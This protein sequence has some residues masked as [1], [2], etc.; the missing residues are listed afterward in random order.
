MPQEL[1]NLSAPLSLFIEPTNFCNFKCQVCPESLVD[2]EEQA[3]Y[4]QKMSQQTWDLLCGQLQSWGVQFPVIR[5]YGMGEPTLNPLLPQM[6]RDVRSFGS[7]TELTTNGSRLAWQAQTLIYSGLSYVRVSIYGTDD[8]EYQTAT[9]SRTGAS[10]ILE[11]VKAFW[12]T[13]NFYYDRGELEKKPWLSVSLVSAN[14]DE[15][16]FRKQYEGVADDLQVERLH[17]WGGGDPRLVQIGTPQESRKSRKVCP[18]PFYELMVR[19]DGSV[20]CCCLDWNGG[21]LVGNIHQQNLQTIWNG[22]L[23]ASWHRLHLTGQR[24][25]IPVCRNCTMIDS[26]PDNM[27]GLLEVE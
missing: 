24:S 27:D 14:P 19:A 12:R 11:Q 26:L 3:G 2:F 25:T 7:R 9:G 10:Q 18:K 22:N 17:N 15:A 8:D 16:T 13:R 6:I 23:L 5:F 4:Y 1:L 21:L 20:S